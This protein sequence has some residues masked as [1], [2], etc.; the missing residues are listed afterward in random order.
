MDVPEVIV[1]HSVYE[2]ATDS[3]RVNRGFMAEFQM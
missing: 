3:D 1:V 2:G